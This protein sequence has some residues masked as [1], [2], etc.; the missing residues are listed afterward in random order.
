MDNSKA[1]HVS[2]SVDSKGKLVCQPHV[3][4]ISG[5]DAVLR[6][7]LQTAG[8]VFPKRDAVVVA[9]PGEEFPFPSRTLPPNDTKA[10][11]YDR[12]TGAGNFN[13]TVHVQKVDSG[14]MLRV[15]PVINN[16]G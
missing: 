12:N 3:L 4:S 14:E 15:D 7:S 9:D 5:S 10:T 6:F 8:Y 16:E 11:L 2:V 1:D 13:Y